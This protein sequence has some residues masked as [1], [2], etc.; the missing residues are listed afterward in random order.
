MDL[1]LEGKKIIVTGGTRGIGRAIVDLLAEEGA[2]IVTCARTT[3]QVDA[4]NAAYKNKTQS[5]GQLVRADVCDVRDEAGYKNWLNGVIN[6]LGGLDGFVPN[7]SGGSS[8]GEEGWLTAFEV[9]LMATVRGCEAV[10]LPMAQSG[11]GSIVIISSIAALGS[12]GE[13]GPYGAIKAALTAHS[14]HLAKAAGQY[15]IRVNSVSPG[16]IHVEDG[17]WGE[18]ARSA[19]DRYK[20]I[21]QLH[22]QG[23]LGSPEEVANAVA[24]LISQKAASWV[25][26]TNLIVD[27]GMTDAV[28][29]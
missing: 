11:G 19:P 24:F 6:D 9:D 1:G 2:D 27:G 17:F 4:F 16:P 26:G 8:A 21:C 18:V 22:P 10:L 7:V 25:T 3:E 5:D 14:G 20:Q 12:F 15:G 23:R 28:Q 29:Y 13:P